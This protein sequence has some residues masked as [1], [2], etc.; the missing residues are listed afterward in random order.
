V[1]LLNHGIPRTTVDQIFAFSASFFKLPQATKDSLGW[2]TPE[3]NRGYLSCGREKATNFDNFDVEA[4]R[5]AAP[6]LKE[7]LEIG[8]EG[9]DG[10]PNQWPKRGDWESADAFKET[11]VDFFDT[12][13]GLHVRIMRA[14]A[15]GLGTKEEWF[16]GFVDK[17]DNILRLLH[18]PS[19]KVEM[20]RKSKLQARAGEHTDFGECAEMHAP[21]LLPICHL[22]GQGLIQNRFNNSSLPRF[23]RRPPGPLAKQG[24]CECST[25]PGY[26]RC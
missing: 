2:T 17:G 5:L 24:L 21:E 20:F 25:H 23:S 13:K 10:C 11:M 7:S 9:Q 4:L 18:Y 26:Y 12:C 6:D 14:I 22:E 3:V 8:R 19:V 1:Y 16:D 15:L